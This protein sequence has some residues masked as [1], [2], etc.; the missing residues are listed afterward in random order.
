MMI[1]ILNLL[2]YADQKISTEDT[3]T[4]FVEKYKLLKWV[5]VINNTSKNKI[6]DFK[7]CPLRCSKGFQFKIH[8]EMQ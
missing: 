1:L 4:N 6:S 8:L 5:K 3:Q 7:A 2:A